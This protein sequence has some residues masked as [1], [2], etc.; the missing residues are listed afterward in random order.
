MNG[1]RLLLFNNY[2][3]LMYQLCIILLLTDDPWQLR[4]RPETHE[5][6]LCNAHHSVTCSNTIN[7]LF[8]DINVMNYQQLEGLEQDMNLVRD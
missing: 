5:L 6:L 1:G 7:P 3:S 8:Y 4:R 2:A